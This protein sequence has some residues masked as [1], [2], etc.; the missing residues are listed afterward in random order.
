MQKKPSQSEIDQYNSQKLDTET[1][2]INFCKLLIGLSAASI[3]F[4]VGSVLNATSKVLFSSELM[5][6]SWGLSGLSILSCCA[7]IGIVLRSKY[8]YLE[9]F[10]KFIYGETSAEP[11]YP[12]QRARD[13]WAYSGIATFALGLIFLALAVVAG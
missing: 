3:S 12:L 5:Y 4:T 9:R 13:I 8:V 7:F 1:H 2:L 10:R 6:A 11:T